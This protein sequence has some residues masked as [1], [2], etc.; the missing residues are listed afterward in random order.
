[1]NG[2]KS[3]L[4]TFKSSANVQIY[5]Y[6]HKVCFLGIVWEKWGQ[7]EW[8]RI[9]Q[10]NNILDVFC[11]TFIMSYLYYYL[12]YH[13]YYMLVLYAIKKKN[14]S[15]Q[16]IVA[17]SYCISEIQWTVNWISKPIFKSMIIAHQFFHPFTLSLD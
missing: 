9:S 12:L 13:I 1:M 4:N 14:V 16:H 11:A 6:L 17:K 10:D 7:V 8:D 2:Q 3:K 5:H 15:N